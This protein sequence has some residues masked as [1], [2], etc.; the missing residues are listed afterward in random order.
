MTL[1]VPAAILF[2]VPAWI[3]GSWLAL[4]IS[5]PDLTVSALVLSA[6]MLVQ[7]VAGIVFLVRR[8]MQVNR[9]GVSH[10]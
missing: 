4:L 2:L 6:L 1:A 5:V 3:Q 10:T 8:S 9:K 7:G